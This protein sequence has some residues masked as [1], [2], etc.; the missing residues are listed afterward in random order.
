MTRHVVSLAQG[1]PFQGVIA[2]MDSVLTRMAALHERAWQ[3]AFNEYFDLCCRTENQQAELSHDEY[4]Q[5]LDG[6]LRY[7]GATDLLQAR[8]LKLPMGTVEDEPGAQTVC[9]IGN[10]KEK[11]LIELLERGGVAVFADALSALRRWRLSGIKLAAISASCNCQSVLRIVELEKYLDVI[12]D[13]EQAR[14][15]GLGSKKEM[16]LEAAKRLGVEPASTAVLEDTA[17]G[18]RAGV[19]GRF[20]LTVGVNRNHHAAELEHAGADAVVW[21]LTALRFPRSLPSALHAAE[22]ILSPH[23]EKPLAIFLDF[24]G[25]LAPIVED[26]RHVKLSDSVISTLR[27]L[28]GLCTLGLIS[29]RDRMDLQERVGIDGL[30]YAGNHGLDIA[31][32]GYEKS[33]PEAEA[34]VPQIERATERLREA[35]ETIPG[36]IIER[37]RFGVA[38]HFRQVRSDVE[39]QQIK[40][41]VDTVLA[42][43]ELRMREGKQVLELEPAVAWDKGDAVEWFLETTELDADHVLVIY[44]GDDE[45]DEDVFAA[46]AGRGVSIVVD[47]KLS[48]S[49]ADY[50]L[51]DPDEVAHFLQRLGEHCRQER[52]PAT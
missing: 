17:A 10:R 30:L 25:T 21:S 42:D 11:V 32:P 49:L 20:G 46:L 23:P 45:T 39:R 28:S 31:G 12:V 29:G 7:Q 43:T 16:M 1:A 40:R 4:R 50:R 5:Y 6:K 15:L 27:S 13:G 9:G 52:H 26:P 35:L 3:V 22:Q 47:E 18:I 38:V 34:A 33:L 36:A 37:K 51:A 14:E 41:V 44:I 48:N 2:D 8:H 19:E 24:D